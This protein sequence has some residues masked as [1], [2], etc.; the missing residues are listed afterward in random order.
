MIK[1]RVEINGSSGGS[2]KRVKIIPPRHPDGNRCWQWQ[3]QMSLPRF[4][5]RRWRWN[6]AEPV[7]RLSRYVYRGGT[8]N[9]RERR[10]QVRM[11]ERRATSTKLEGKESELA[12]RER[13]R[14]RKREGTSRSQFSNGPEKVVVIHLLTYITLVS[15]PPRA[16]PTRERAASAQIV[17]LHTGRTYTS[18]AWPTKWHPATRPR[19]PRREHT[20]PDHPLSFI[21]KLCHAIA[22][23]PKQISPLLPRQGADPESETT[24]VWLCVKMARQRWENRK[25]KF[26]TREKFGV[27]IVRLYRWTSKYDDVIFCQR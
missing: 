13:E 22:P 16:T 24:S 27:E 8:R 21:P 25:R 17:P 20:R 11:N 6:G 4:S 26:H 19:P 18:S 10:T 5:I 2:S 3:S 7:S 9:A 23:K 12:T 15:P 14:E 1:P